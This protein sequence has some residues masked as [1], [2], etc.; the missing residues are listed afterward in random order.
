MAASQAQPLAHIYLIPPTPTYLSLMRPQ[1]LTENRINDHMDREFFPEKTAKGTPV[2]TW[3]RA[4]PLG[5][6]LIQGPQGQLPKRG[7]SCPG[8]QTIVNFCSSAGILGEE[9]GS[10]C[11]HLKPCYSQV[12]LARRSMEPPPIGRVHMLFPTHPLSGWC[13]SHESTLKT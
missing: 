11:P 12:S 7:T 5:S 10:L 6:S 1:D 2:Q 3:A 9:M 8:N 13:S 4:Y